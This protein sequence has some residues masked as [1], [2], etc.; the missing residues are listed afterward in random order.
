VVTV[1]QGVSDLDLPQKI[2]INEE[3]VTLKQSIVC[4]KSITDLETPLFIGV[5][6]KWNGNIVATSDSSLA[7]E[8]QLFI[9]HLPLYLEHA[10]RNM[11]W[12][13]FLPEHRIFME[14]DFVYDNNDGVN[15][16]VDKIKKKQSKQ[17]IQKDKNGDAA[18]Q[19]NDS[20]STI[21][22]DDY[23]G[24]FAAESGAAREAYETAASCQPYKYLDDQED[25]IQFNL[26]LQITLEIPVDADGIIGDDNNSTDT[27]ALGVLAATA[28]MV[29]KTTNVNYLDESS[30]IS[31]LT[32]NLS[33]RGSDKKKE[34]QTLTT[35]TT[36]GEAPGNRRQDTGDE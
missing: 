7:Q 9:A 14:E 27:F 6:M 29:D 12:K 31:D 11:I 34:E 26:L 28:A 19:S 22:S 5:D 13:W 17:Q 33:L 1:I 18:M 23:A 2:R 21:D 35:T 3:K 15:R 8:A 10:L 16:V 24:V 36:T 32:G 20:T 25:N 4:V 30:V